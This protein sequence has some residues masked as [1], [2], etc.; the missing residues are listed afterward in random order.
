MGRT[1]TIADG[2]PL[3]AAATVPR[4]SLA[5]L[6]QAP[7]RAARRQTLWT[8]LTIFG[9]CCAA[10]V[11]FGIWMP[12]QR[13]LA[14]AMIF[15]AAGVCFMWAFCLSG[16][17][18]LGRDARLL[19]LPGAVRNTTLSA[20][21]YGALTIVLPTS[22][23]AAFGANPAVA[24]MLAA[25]ALVAGL[26]FVLL[27]RWISTW[28]GFV[29]AIYIALHQGLHILS[30]FSTGFLYTGLLAIAVL[31]ALAVIRWRRILRGNTADMGGWNTPIILALHQQAVS[32][33]WSFDKQLLWQR[34]ARESRFTN[35]RGINARAPAKAI[36]VCLGALY[37]PQTAAGNLRRLGM[38]AWPV[39][40]FGLAMLLVNVGH[41]HD[42]HK[43]VA[44]IG[45]SG[46]MWSSVFGITMVL[47][48]VCAMLKRRWEQG[49]EPALLA[50]LPGLG[51]HVPLS[52]SLLRATFAK[53]FGV[54][55]ALWALM[56][57]CEVWL[58]LGV[59]AVALTSL[60]VFGMSAAAAMVL[61]R[62]FA[63]RPLRN[64]VQALI[65]GSTF[66]LVCV[67]LPLVF[68]TPLA[69]LG[70]TAVGIEWALILVWL[71]FGAWMTVMAAHAWGMLKARPHP[72]LASAP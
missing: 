58:Q 52:C 32:A 16:L 20:L 51:Q 30:P 72:F 66:V 45:I 63:G 1:L 13:G 61:L 70:L 38:I 8:T 34:G 29:P 50:L 25:L 6:L 65:A 54:C 71:I 33:G 36:E 22:I 17:L 2:F 60:V 67:C 59:A 14:L 7:W 39:L 12:G 27:P 18:L 47:F 40:V 23:E 11:A 5:S 9:L 49:R 43:L 35:L 24:A 3:P 41:I 21:V 62:V 48:A 56:I 10:A 26:A 57:A 44:L 19:A 55:V 68:V 53:P 42:L 31:L 28:M 64:L 15:Y 69:K 4:S 46:A 37:T